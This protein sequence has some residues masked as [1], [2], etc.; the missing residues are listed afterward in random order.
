MPTSQRS[1][2]RCVI[3]SAGHGCQPVRVSVRTYP[4]WVAPG[5]MVEGRTLLP[6]PPYTCTRYP[7]VGVPVGAGFRSL[8]CVCRVDDLYKSK[9]KSRMRPQFDMRLE[10]S[11]SHSH[12]HQT[13]SQSHLALTCKSCSYASYMSSECHARATGDGVY[14]GSGTRER[15]GAKQETNDGRSWPLGVVW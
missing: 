11:R 9:E 14:D 1:V 3:R 15:L 13:C 8:V 2:G 5:W 12:S 6:P 7:P 10:Y 4:H